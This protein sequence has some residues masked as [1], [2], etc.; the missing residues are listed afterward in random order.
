M[1]VDPNLRRKDL[2]MHRHLELPEYES[3]EFP[4]FSQI[5]LSITG[6]CNRTC[7]F[8]PRVDPEVYPNV[9]EN[10]KIE[11]HAKIVEELGRYQYAGLIG[12][13]GFSEPFLHKQLHVML[14]QGRA[15]CPKARQEVYTNGDFVTVETLRQ[16]FDAGMTSLHISMYDGPQQRGEFEAVLAQGGFSEDQVILRNRYLPREQQYGLTLSNRAGMISFSKTGVQP[17]REP[18][19]LQCFYPFYMMMVDH[20]GDVMICSHDWGKKLV[21]GNLERQSV[22]EVWTSP[23]MRSVRQLLGNSDRRLPACREC[24]VQGTHI[25]RDHFER[26][27]DY[28]RSLD[29]AAADRV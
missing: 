16:L 17:L 10:M 3:V 5:E 21:V 19:K 2:L 14:A 22:S 26:W 1:N 23:R 9:N 15:A 18:L 8:C 7:E 13:S 24:D 20:K 28:Y 25:G 11:L 6:L 27:Q 12:Y 29:P 4:L